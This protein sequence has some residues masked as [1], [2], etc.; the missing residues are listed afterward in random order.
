[1]TS[2]EDIKHFIG[3]ILNY[4][5]YGFDLS[6]SRRA[7]IQFVSIFICIIFAG[8][9]GL[10]AGFSVKYCKCDIA[11]M[12]FNDSEYFDVSESEPF[13]WEDETVIKINKK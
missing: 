11:A 10:I 5:K 8:I 4:E 13:P 12:L 7:G 6:F 1:M 9:S 3:G 2:K